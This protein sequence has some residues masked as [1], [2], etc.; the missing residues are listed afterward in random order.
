M[1]V[2]VHGCS[3]MLQ[4]WTGG[5]LM[6][7][8]GSNDG[9][10]GSIAGHDGQLMVSWWVFTFQAQRLLTNIPPTIWE[11]DVLSH[12]PTAPS[13]NQSCVKKKGKI[14]KMFKTATCHH[15]PHCA[16]S[17]AGATRLSLKP[18][19]YQDV[20]SISTSTC[21]PHPW[22]LATPRTAAPFFTHDVVSL[23]PAPRPQHLQGFG[24]APQLHLDALAT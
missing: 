12:F 1:F 5:Q 3:W 9:S 7:H 19:T 8:H 11:I 6:V 21:M 16:R 14:N 2:D 10:Q 4:C 18:P 20:K 22:R 13:T 15:F 24:L 23:D 17:S